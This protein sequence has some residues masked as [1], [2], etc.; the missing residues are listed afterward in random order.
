MIGPGLVALEDPKQLPQSLDRAD[1][2]P[3]HQ[4]R[5]GGGH[6]GN[7]DG[8]ALDRIYQRDDA[9]YGPDRSIQPQLTQEPKPT[10][11]FLREIPVGHQ[12]TH[13]HGEIQ[14]AAHLAGP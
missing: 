14:P 5:I 1:L 13:G 3:V 4:H 10:S 7:D 11:L 6:H 12:H 9:R 8:F 2:W